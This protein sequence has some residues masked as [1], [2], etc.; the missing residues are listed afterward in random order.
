MV[1][2]VVL[3]LV[4]SICDMRLSLWISFSSNLEGSVAPQPRCIIKK[5]DPL[6]TE[7]DQHAYQHPGSGSQP[8]AKSL[9]SLCV[10]FQ[11]PASALS[12]RPATLNQRPQ[13]QHALPLPG[14]EEPKNF[15]STGRKPGRRT[16]RPAE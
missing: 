10:S 16:P 8:Q 4:P 11:S 2:V 6:P 14:A 7:R 13:T 12:R 5:G 9:K 15:G 1:V 3:L